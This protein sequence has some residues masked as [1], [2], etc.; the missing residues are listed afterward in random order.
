MP[1]RT[2]EELEKKYQQGKESIEFLAL[3]FLRAR[4]DQGSPECPRGGE[5][6][7]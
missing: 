2:P 6:L 3:P 5:T 7:T 4:P 1:L